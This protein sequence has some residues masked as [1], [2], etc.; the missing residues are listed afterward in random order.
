MGFSLV[1]NKGTG[2]TIEFLWSQLYPTSLKVPQREELGTANYFEQRHIL[3]AAGRG[4]HSRHQLQRRTAGEKNRVLSPPLPHAR[5]AWK[6]SRCRGGG[7]NYTGGN[8]MMAPHPLVLSEPG[9]ALGTAKSK[10]VHQSAECIQNTW[11]WLGYIQANRHPSIL[12]ISG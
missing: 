4:G 11:I 8:A 6:W 5:L 9:T 7:C 12:G 3:G 10:S 2:Y 1:A